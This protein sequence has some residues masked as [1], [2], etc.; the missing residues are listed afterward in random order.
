M[1][2]N[3]NAPNKNELRRVIRQRRAALDDRTTR[4]AAICERFTTLEVYERAQSI[5]CYLPMGEEVDTWPL[6]QHALAVGKAVAVPIVQ[7][8]TYEL[9][10]T[11]L[12]STALEDMEPGVFGTSHPRARVAC[13]PAMCDLIVVPLLAFDRACQRLGYGKGYYDR[14]LARITAPAIGVAFTAQEVDI[15]PSAPHD[16]PLAAVVTEDEIVWKPT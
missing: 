9:A 1:P 4:N 12:A 7:R 10:H 11:W 15:V 13:D 8:D 5:H 2:S 14:L 6:V 16:V 3:P